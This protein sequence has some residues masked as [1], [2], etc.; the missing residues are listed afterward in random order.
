MEQ[1][2]AVSLEYAGYEQYEEM[3]PGRP[4]LQ[5]DGDI[6][7]NAS[8]PAVISVAPHTIVIIGEFDNTYADYDDRK[9]TEEL[10]TFVRNLL[11]LQ[12]IPA[13]A[14]TYIDFGKQLL[15]LTQAYPV[16]IVDEGSPAGSADESYQVNGA[17]AAR[18][19]PFTITLLFKTKIPKPCYESICTQVTE[20][21]AW[22]TIIFSLPK[23]ALQIRGVF[24]EQHYCKPGGELMEFLVRLA[25]DIWARNELEKTMVYIHISFAGQI[26]RLNRTLPDV[27]VD[28]SVTNGTERSSI[29]AT[30]TFASGRTV[31]AIADTSNLTTPPD[32]EPGLCSLILQRQIMHVFGFTTWKQFLTALP[33]NVGIRELADRTYAIEN[34]SNSSNG[35]RLRISP[36]LRLLSEWFD[37]RPS[38]RV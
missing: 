18:T 10:V 24:G 28:A 25:E 3:R 34:S 9:L 15:G 2:Y 32:D 29:K 26:L 14:F 21:T 19:R 4:R 12:D 36:D 31:Q 30:L 7:R 11:N 17:R 38:N 27:I 6:L 13:V 5:V 23:L 16:A 33:L 35:R 20:S 22:Q 1:S 8:M 37:R